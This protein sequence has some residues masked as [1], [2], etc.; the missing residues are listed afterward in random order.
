M[1]GQKIAMGR[2]HAGQV[3]TVHVAEHTLTIDLAD[4]D[5]RTVRRTTRRN[6][7]ARDQRSV[8]SLTGQ[9]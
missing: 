4:G 8:A 2:I 9:T 7:H 1:V 3:V 5:S 6:A